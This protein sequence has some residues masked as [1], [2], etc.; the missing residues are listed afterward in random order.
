VRDGAIE[1]TVGRTTYK[2]AEDDC[3]AMKLDAPV[4]FRNRTRRTA[5]YLVVLAS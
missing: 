4:T 2:L 3:L 5:H 1:I